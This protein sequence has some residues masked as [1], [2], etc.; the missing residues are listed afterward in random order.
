MLQVI[1]GVTASSIRII[2]IRVPFSSASVFFPLE[3]P[4]LGYLTE[5][6]TTADL[7][8]RVTGTHKPLHHRKVETPFEEL[9]SIHFVTVF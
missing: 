8:F 5:N 9:L 7:M 4:G 2:C 1:T 6:S 3:L